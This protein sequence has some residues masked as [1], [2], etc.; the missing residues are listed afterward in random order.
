MNNG[1]IANGNESL[2]SLTKDDNEVEKEVITP[3]PDL[4][5]PPSIIPLKSL[6]ENYEILEELGNGSF[7]SVTLVKFKANPCENNKDLHKK[8]LTM[9]DPKYNNQPER[10]SSSRKQGLVAIK[11]MLTRLPTLNDYTRVREIKFILA[12]PASNFLI[13]VFDIFIDTERYHLNIVME[14]MEQNLYQMMKRRNKRV[15]S[16]PSLKSILAQV[17]SGLRHIHNQNFF[18][19]DLKPENILITPSTRYFDKKWL[20]EGNY[21]DNYVVKLAD[22]GLARHVENKNPYTAYVST[23]WY[24]SPEILLRSGYYS[25]PLDIWAFGCVAVEVT[26]FKP[27]FPGANEI[28]QIWKILE[29]L[30]TP[31]HIE[32]VMP[33]NHIPQG[34]LWEVSK[35]YAEKLN[36]KFP[37]V[38]G[39]PLENIIPSSQLSDLLDVIKMCLRW[40]PNDRAPISKLCSMPFFRDTVAD[41]LIYEKENK[42]ENPHFLKSIAEQAL[43]FAGIHSN[44]KF[45]NINRN[46]KLR[47]DNEDDENAAFVC[48]NESNICASQSLSKNQ[49]LRYNNDSKPYSSNSFNNKKLADKSRSQSS[50][51]I[52]NNVSSNSNKRQKLNIDSRLSLNEFLLRNCIVDYTSECHSF[53]KNQTFV[54]RKMTNSANAFDSTFIHGISNW[55]GVKQKDL[56]SEIQNELYGIMHPKSNDIRSK[57]L[58]IMHEEIDNGYN[59][60][61]IKLHDIARE[62]ASDNATDHCNID[63]R[64]EIEEL[65]PS[66]NHLLDNMSLDE[67]SMEIDS[68]ATHSAPFLNVPITNQYLTNGQR[69]A[70]YDNRADI[71]LSEEANISPNIYSIESSYHVVGNVTF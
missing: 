66:V 22:F 15:F 53:S 2:Q 20:N 49:L 60:N 33:R 37:F 38:T 44:N 5:H 67:F 13:Q 7:G 39:S 1:N 68:Y 18:H 41:Q 45:I 21:P 63:N 69:V 8:S 59:Y 17:L 6:Q 52:I 25:K 42:D 64:R 56:K 26:V 62:Q 54:H 70:G 36:L 24:R 50:Y 3:P 47:E 27:L 19:R 61:G 55:E 10:I 28:D 12:I 30:G 48:G 57:I 23:R 35:T 31:H 65:A 40:D 29:V 58:D 71:N 32:N 16:I 34:G 4:K 9:M 11:T 51:N 46:I 14:Y 43:L